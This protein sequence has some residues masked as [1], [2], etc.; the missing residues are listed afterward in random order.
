MKVLQKQNN[1]K[2]VKYVCWT[3][4]QTDGRA[5]KIIHKSSKWHI[6]I[7]LESAVNLIQLEV[8]KITA[9]LRKD[10]RRS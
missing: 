7:Y 6:E 8:P 3:E 9:F 2:E 4:G 10:Y 1:G 5:D